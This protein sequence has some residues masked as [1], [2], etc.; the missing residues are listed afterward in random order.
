MQARFG[1]IE[2]PRSIASTIEHA[3]MA[4]AAGFNW[5]GVAYSQSLFRELFVTLGVV[6]QATKKVM[7]G[8]TVTNPITRHPAVM[9][10]AIASVQ[11]ITNGR[12]MLGLGTGD[13]ALYNL[14]ERPK[15]LKGLR[16]YITTCL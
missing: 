6:G 1:I 5:F 7:I 8:P 14:D 10:S 16:E 13:S 11:E 3:L 2:V 15:G 4:E 9:A 12:V